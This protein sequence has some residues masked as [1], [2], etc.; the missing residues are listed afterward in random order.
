MLLRD[1]QEA[2]DEVL[3]DDLW[4]GRKVLYTLRMLFVPS[5]NLMSL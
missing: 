4:W 3:E 5:S 2:L 1:T